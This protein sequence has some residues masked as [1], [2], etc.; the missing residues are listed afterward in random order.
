MSTLRAESSESDTNL[1]SKWIYVRLMGGILNE[2]HNFQNSI[3]MWRY[4]GIQLINETRVYV[5]SNNRRF[6]EKRFEEQI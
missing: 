2:G 6:M 3:R 5:A 1:N 4:R